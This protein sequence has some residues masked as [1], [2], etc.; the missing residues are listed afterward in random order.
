MITQLVCSYFINSALTSIQIWY[1]YRQP[2]DYWALIILPS[3]LLVAFDIKT[4]FFGSILVLFA[5]IESGS[6]F[7]H[8]INVRAVQYNVIDMVAHR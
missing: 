6:T 3:A 5:A 4:T 7:Y 1:S 2:L 8:Q